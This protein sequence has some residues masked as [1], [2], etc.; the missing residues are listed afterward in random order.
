[1]AAFASANER[2]FVPEGFSA[3]IQL[4]GS[5]YESSVYFVFSVLFGKFVEMLEFEIENRFLI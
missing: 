3:W 5:L 1:M 4:A 2:A